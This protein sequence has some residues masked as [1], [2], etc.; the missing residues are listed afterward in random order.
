MAAA[1]IFIC[2]AQPDA[3]FAE[4]LGLALE[5]FRLS[6][7][8]D[9]HRLRGGERLAPEVRWAIERARQVIVVLGL[10]TG[11]SAWLRREI[12][13]AQE[14]ERRRAD[15]YRVIPL[16]L[17]GVD[18]ALLA[19]WFTPPPRTIP[20]QLTHAGLGAALPDLLTTLGAPLP[21]DNPSG[22]NPPPM[23]E[24][25]LCFS[26]DDSSAA[27]C[28]RLDAHLNRHPGHWPASDVSMALGPLPD[29]PA[30]RLLH[31]YLQSHPCWPTDTVRHLARRIDTLLAAWGHA[32]YRITLDAPKLRSLTAAWRDAPEPC[33]HRLTVRVA[34]AHPA[35]AA[36][37]QLPWELLHDA[38]GFLIQRKQPVQFLRRL[39]GASEVLP[40][41]PPPLRVLAISPRP[42]TEP[43]GH[44]DYRRGALPL[45]EALGDLGDLVEPRVLTPPTLAA[46]EKRLNDA[47]A[48]GRPFVALHLDGYLRQER[49][50]DTLLFGFEASYDLQTPVCREAHF[51]AA[52]TLASLLA[53]YRIRLVALCPSNATGSAATVGLASALLAAGV[54]AVVTLH[55]D[56]P[57]E[58][59]RRFWAT[60]YEELLRGARISQA[61]FASQRRLAS[62]PYRAAGLGGGGVHL[63]DWSCCKLYL[64]RHDPRL[65]VRPPLE[66]WRRLLK[67]NRAGSPGRLPELP[68]TGFIGRGRD[69]LVAERL[70]EERTAVFVRGPNGSGKTA[71][72]V[73]LA[74]W[75]T[76][77]GHYRHVAYVDDG[78][79]GDPPALLETLGRQLLPEG[80][81]WSVGR[82]PT[83]WL[84][85]DH[86]RQALRAQPVLIVLDQL[87]RWP[88][89]HDETFDQLWKRLLNEWPG[90]RLLGLGR[91]GPPPFAQPWVE[92]TLSPMDDRDAIGLIG[93]TL[94]A[95]R[96]IPPATDSG[97]GFHQLREIAA[98]AGGQPGALRRLAREIGMQGVGAT[99]ALARPLRAELLRQHSDDPQWPLYL[100]LELAIRQ[101]P[102]ADRDRLAILAFFKE[103][104][105]R[106]ALG[107]ALTLDT[108]TLDGFCG[109]LFALGLAEDQGY[110]HLRFDPPLSHYLASQLATQ[111]RSIWRERW[112][113]GMEQ[114]LAVLYQRYFKDNARTTRLL[115]LELPNLLALLR[116]YQQQLATPEKTAHLAGRL[117]QLLANLGVP[118][119]LAEVVA[120]RERAGQGLLDWNRIRFETERLRIERLRDSGSL[121]EALRATRQLLH[122][123]QAA[124]PDAYAGAGYDLARAHFQLGKLL[125]LAGAAEPA[126]RELTTARQRFQALAD[127]GNGSAGRMVAVAE[128]ETGDCL[129]Y[130]QRLQEAAAAYEAALAHAGPNAVNLSVAANQ[131]Q[132]GLVRQR[133][134]SY[135]EAAALYAA[136]GQMFDRLG[137]PEGTARAWRQLGL[138][139]KLNGQLEPALQACQ[140]AL[141]RYEQQRNRAGVAE[142]LGELGHL[143]QALNQLE[144]AAMAYRRMAELCAQLGD[145]LGEE[146]GRN[147]LANIL[148][149]LRR[150]DEARQELYRA[151]ECNPPDSPT[152]RNWTIRRGL[153]DVGQAA[154]NPDVADQARRQAI[155]KYLAYRR[156]GGENTNPGARLCAQIGHAIR[157]G[158]TT[159]LAAKLEQIAASPNVPPAGKL[160]IAKLRA[161]LTGSRDPALT[162]DPN[163]HYQYAVELQ[164]LLE[165]LASP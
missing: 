3:A 28:W 97:N 31:W 108:P 115:R 5:T 96:A 25:E 140:Q 153:R 125:K 116:D 88:S 30:P 50:S 67:Q 165:E 76:Q 35:A 77:C 121:E 79:A 33:E 120:A 2:H 36:V 142:T 13:L 20:I 163:L 51:V 90:L 62:D 10:N 117:E 15:D 39:S 159:K 126:V 24:L 17:P 29:P 95:T 144:E 89:E 21:G 100:S 130:L 127:A 128:A 1:S 146:I 114:L 66:I 158:D 8:R 87:E 162:T 148:I 12:E 145:G 61:L 83:W 106:I 18:Q 141:Y 154:Q 41:A 109:R 19:C 105:N 44:P 94:I 102:A 56:T 91:L 9:S 143:H 75:L 155:Q 124:G 54:A 48:A 84:A 137:E 23:A 139:R 60:F 110:G 55:P 63:R 123:C 129:T 47:W 52:A 6:V 119:A 133:Q 135:A 32:L 22:R 43:T 111:Q 69:L 161:I 45:L 68:S 152:A 122:Q 104:A 132:L 157:A 37:F 136:A 26:R 164:L 101:L 40:P 147:K 11:E 74:H 58:T 160:L 93:R 42:D 27:G 92:T 82:Y 65:C 150:H 64:A 85:L 46:L 99:L 149:Q 86:L 71:A 14:V 103:G 70:L 38:T 57:A 73:A 49:D 131:L 72:A 59:L 151:S 113:A 112:R 4:D 78:D 7:W 98:L 53:A 156:A 134:G 80:K 34:E 16:L 118:A 81:H 107:S 138:A